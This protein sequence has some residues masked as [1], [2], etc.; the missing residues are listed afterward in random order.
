MFIHSTGLMGGQLGNYHTYCDEQIL[1]VWKIAGLNA[2]GPVI[3]CKPQQKRNVLRCPAVSAKVKYP[4][5]NE[6]FQ[7]QKPMALYAELIERYAPEKPCTVAE[8]TGKCS[9]HTLSWLVELVVCSLSSYQSFCCLF[10][11]FWY[12]DV[13]AVVAGRKWASWEWG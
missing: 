6:T 8:L 9:V 10:R 1:L 3:F 13:H 2:E 4:G 12:P 7:Y 5:S 11:W